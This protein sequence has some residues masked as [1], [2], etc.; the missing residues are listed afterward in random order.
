MFTFHT[1]T[2]DTVSGNRKGPFTRNVCV[3]F[4][5]KVYI[6]FMAKNGCIRYVSTRPNGVF[7]LHENENDTE[8]DK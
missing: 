1:K 4:N 3:C 8:N 5:E 2:V 7:T 6:K